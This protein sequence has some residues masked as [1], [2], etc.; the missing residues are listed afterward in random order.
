MEPTPELITPEAPKSN[1]MLIIAVVVVLLLCC[2]CIAIG[3]LGWTFGDAI[4]ESLD[5]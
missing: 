4:I 1:K 5:L 3:A 2:C